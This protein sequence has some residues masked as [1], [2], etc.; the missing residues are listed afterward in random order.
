MKKSIFILLTA[1]LMLSSC[2]ESVIEQIHPEMKGEG[3]L[4]IGL[5][6]DENLQIVSTKAS[7]LDES[8]VPS[9]EELYV[10]LYKYEVGKSGK[11]WWKRL[12]F[13]TY[14]EMFESESSEEGDIE[15]VSGD[16]SVEDTPVAVEK[17]FKPLRVN[18]GQWR[19]MAFHG[20]STACGRRR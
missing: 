17:K 19:L 3:L 9:V 20:D 18:A 11:G 16:T 13:S 6:V 15:T 1:A 5:S 10:E 14:S 8:L 12:H 7:G 2:A 4:Q